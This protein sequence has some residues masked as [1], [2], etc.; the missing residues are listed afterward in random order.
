[1][2]ALCE[3]K[4]LKELMDQKKKMYYFL[5]CF[6]YFLKFWLQNYFDMF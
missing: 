3:K 4:Q 2:C 5:Q 6:S 1:M